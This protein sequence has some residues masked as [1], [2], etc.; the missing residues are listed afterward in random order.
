MKIWMDKR[1]RI[2]LS[3]ALREELGLAQGDRV[4]WIVRGDGI[5]L[6]PVMD[7]RSIVIEKVDGE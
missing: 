1:G 7:R 4:E 2:T 3:K 6:L 5:Q